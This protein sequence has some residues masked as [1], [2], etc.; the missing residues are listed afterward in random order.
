MIWNE[1]AI[2][3]LLPFPTSYYPWGWICFM[4]FHRNNRLPQAESGSSNESKLSSMKPDIKVICANNGTFSLIFFCGGRSLIF[5]K[6]Y[7]L[8]YHVM[9]F[10]Y[11]FLSV[12]SFLWK[13]MWAGDGERERGTEDPKWALSWQQRALCAT[14]THD[15]EIVTW[16]KV[17]C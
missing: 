3:I 14:Q 13:R 5:I 7:Y 9:G 2:K 15:R 4:C 8:Y 10:L 12:Y 17:R 16:A 6:T 11:I 1:K